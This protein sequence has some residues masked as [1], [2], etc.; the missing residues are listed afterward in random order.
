MACEQLTPQGQY[1]AWAYQMIPEDSR[2]LTWG[3]GAESLR[4]SMWTDSPV[5]ISNGRTLEGEQIRE[6]IF[7]RNAGLIR[8]RVSEDVSPGNRLYSGSGGVIISHPP[9][10][11]PPSFGLAL[12]AASAGEHAKIY[13][14]VIT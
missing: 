10:I 11:G 5:A 1:R 2:L 9:M 12:T 13:I 7:F 3:P 14:G 8:A 6:V 4:L